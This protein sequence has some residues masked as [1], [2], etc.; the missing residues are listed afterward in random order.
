MAVT[1]ISVHVLDSNQLMRP[2]PGPARVRAHMDSPSSTLSRRWTTSESRGGTNRKAQAVALAAGCL[3]TVCACGTSEG[4]TGAT[5]EST[6]TAPAATAAPPTTVAASTTTASTDTTATTADPSDTT[7][8]PTTDATTTTTL[9]STTTTVSPTTVPADH[10]CLDQPLAPPRLVG[11]GEPGEYTVAETDGDGTPLR[12]TWGADES[13]VTQVLRPAFYEEGPTEL[14][15]IV[16]VDGNQFRQ[17]ADYEAAV[18]PVGDPGVGSISI[19]LRERG[20]DCIRIYTTEPGTSL[21]Q[22]IVFAQVF[23]DELSEAG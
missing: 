19:Y 12:V 3:I 16:P 9:S 5:V 23:V 2:G 7:A 18:I 21:D 13:A 8:A 14:M 15:A 20:T 11:G 1:T 10:V 22:A 6:T 4:D 17:A